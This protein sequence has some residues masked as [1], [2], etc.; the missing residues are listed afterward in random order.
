MNARSAPT[1][2]LRRWIGAGGVLLALAGCQPEQ[3]TSPADADAAPEVAT[4]IVTEEGTTAEP[5][6][7]T[8]TEPI[9]QTGRLSQP[10]NLRVSRLS[11]TRV[12]VRFVDNATEESHYKI[13]R[14]DKRAGPYTALGPFAFPAGTGERVWTN[15]VP[16]T[17]GDA[18]YYLRAWKMSTN[19]HGPVSDSVC[20][21]GTGAQTP[22]PTPESALA[23]TAE[24]GRLSMP[25]NIRVTRLSATLAEVRFLD[26]ATDE[27]HYKIWRDDTQAGPYTALGPFAFPAG[28]GERVWTNAVPSTWSNVCYY[29][30]AWKM[31]TNELGP[32]SAPVCV[33]GS[34]S[35]PAP[36]PEPDPAPAPAPTPPPT[37]GGLWRNEDFSRYTSDDHWRSDPF[38]WMVSAAAGWNQH[39]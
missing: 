18:C 21:S 24:T 10:T 35:A 27:S 31:S 1:H 19:E 17:W 25:T 11:A 26:N 6:L 5:D 22:T 12:E 9:P 36:S 38:D 15:T 28:T 29:L 20:I 7:T 14:D 3:P 37:S 32:V 23:P 39:A 30:R 16:S 34:A 4:E 33:S 8:A 13:W 2:R